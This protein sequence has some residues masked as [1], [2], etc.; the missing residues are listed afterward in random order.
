MA[1]KRSDLLCAKTSRGFCCREKKSSKEPPAPGCLITSYDIA[2]NDV[3]FLMSI[4][5]KYMVVD[6]AHRLK[7]M[8]CRLIKELKR[9]DA[10]NRLLL[11]GTPLQNNLSELWS[12]LNFILPDIFDDLDSFRSWFDFDDT[13]GDDGDNDADDP[14]QPDSMRARVLHSEQQNQIISKLHDILRPFMLRRLKQEC[15]IELPRKREILLFCNLT[16]KQAEQYESIRARQLKNQFSQ[17][18]SLNNTVMQLRKLCNH[19]FLFDGLNPYAAREEVKTTQKEVWKAYDIGERDLWKVKK[20]I[21][22]K[23]RE[24]TGGINLETASKKELEGFRTALVESSGKFVI[25]DKMLT[26]LQNNGHRVLL[27]SQMT[28][29][30]DLLEDFLTVTGRCKWLRL[31]GT[32][33]HKDRQPMIDAFNAEGSDIFLF[34]L[35]TRA[36][37]LGINLLGADT[38]IIYD[39]DWNPQADLQAQDRCHRFGQTKPV[40]VYRMVTANTVESY[41]LRKAAKKRRL[42]NL[43]ISKGR[44]GNRDSKKQQLEIGDLEEA[45]LLKSGDATF[46][47]DCAISDDNLKMILDRSRVM[48]LLDLKE[49]T[50]ATAATKAAVG[51]FEVMED[52]VSPF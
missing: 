4:K 30:L 49:E 15:G 35:S 38:V 39:S 2:M 23:T 6:E 19:P 34:L 32:V 9:L 42:E 29:L 50:A 46:G 24:V 17:P 40:C 25:L 21:T 47:H 1:A 20:I 7:N 5:W 3:K 22:E 11:T 13:V 26:I 31:D 27:F 51:G 18:V 12:L 33:S 45:L 8:Q 16:D 37:G 14:L 43:V 48:E 36:G 28:S 10:S 52:V 44:F 41:L